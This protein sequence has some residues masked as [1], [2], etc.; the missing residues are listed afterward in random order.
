M[1]WLNTPSRCTNICSHTRMASRRIPLLWWVCFT[2]WERPCRV[3]AGDMG[4]GQ[5]RYSTDWVLRL[6]TWSVRLSHTIMTSISTF[7]GIHFDVI[8]PRRI[9]SVRG[10]GNEPIPDII[11]NSI[12]YTFHPVQLFHDPERGQMVKLVLVLL[13]GSTTAIIS[14]RIGRSFPSRMSLYLTMNVIARSH[15]SLIVTLTRS[16]CHE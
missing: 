8:L 15:S 7:S 14:S 2:I 1:D 16:F 4:V 5:W 3:T 11:S 6:Q 10:V 12:P 13:R 9:A